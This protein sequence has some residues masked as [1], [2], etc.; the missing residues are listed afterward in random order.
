M[1]AMSG[2]LVGCMESE[3]PE[4]QEVRAGDEVEWISLVPTEGN[5]EWA[6]VEFGGEGEAEWAQGTM[7]ITRGVDL[8]GMRWDGD[9][10]V[11]PYEIR[12]EARKTLGD[13][14]FCGLSVPVR[15]EEACVT[16]ILGGWGGAVVGISS[17]DGM[18]AS[19]NDTTSFRSFA[20]DQWYRIRM[21]VREDH[22]AAWVDDEQVVDVAIGGREV[23]LRP[24]LIE[25]ASPLGIASFQTDAELRGLEWRKLE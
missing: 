24:G 5:G 3:V 14:F 4:V 7:M 2:L 11:A 10:P 25:L 21:E 16:L 1:L 9:L 22:L 6:V 20:K 8:T 19:E 18:D 23:G 13:D 15:G 17:I 12:L